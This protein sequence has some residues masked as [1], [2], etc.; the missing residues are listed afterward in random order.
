ME[1]QSIELSHIE[2]SSVEDVT[3]FPAGIATAKAFL[4]NVA[5]AFANTPFKPHPVFRNGH[6][7]T[8]AAY[9][10]PRRFRFASE[11]DQERLFEVAP[12]VKILAHCRWQ[13]NPSEHPTI[14]VWHGVEGS[15]SSS[16]MQAMAEKGFHSGFNIVRVNFRNCGG[17]EHLTSTIYHGGLSSDLDAVVRQLLEKDHLTRL[18]LVGFS[19][20]GNLVLKLAGEYGD[21]APREIV[22]VCAVSPSVDLNAAA[23][24]IMK[25]SNWIY[26]QDFVRRLKK[27]IRINHKLYPELYDISGLRSVNTLRGFDDRF[28]SVAHGFIDAADYYYRSSSTRV[29]DHI[30]IPTLIIHAQDDPFIPFAPLREPAIADNPYLLLIGPK[31]GG[32]V[33][34]ISSNHN[35]DTDRFWAENRVMEFC[36]LAND[37]V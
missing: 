19:L 37:S 11:R 13:T 16:Y 17:T 26:Q 21:N 4:A 28:T 22:G 8:I 33:A 5:Q 20:G 24:L 18:F 15:T 30:R 6:A 31:E 3:K 7:Q 35:G 12:G 23:D 14:V 2:P 27:R 29:I 25:R 9:L 34:F 10:W 36:K 32:H 1:F